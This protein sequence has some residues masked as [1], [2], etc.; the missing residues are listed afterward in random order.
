MLAH[1]Q[2][3]SGEALSREREGLMSFITM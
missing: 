1:V 2:L 3:L